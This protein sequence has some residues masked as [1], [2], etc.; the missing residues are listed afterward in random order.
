MNI[1]IFDIAEQNSDKLRKQHQVLKDNSEDK[2]EL[3]TFCSFTEMVKDNWTISI[4]MKEWDLLGFLTSEQYKNRY[5]LNTEYGNKLAEHTELKV[6]T[7][8]TLET[9]LKGFYQSRLTFDDTFKDGR[10]FKYCTL[11][12]GGL[13]IEYGPYCIVM[14]KKRAATYDAL[15]F[16]REDSV[17]YVSGTKVDL[18][19]LSQ[20][21]ANKACVHFLAAIKHEKDISG[22]PPNEW[23]S[24]ICSGKMYI[25]AVT[26]DDVRVTDVESVRISKKDHRPYYQ[27]LYESLISEIS[28]YKKYRLA[29]LSG[30]HNLLEKHG[31]K[32]EELN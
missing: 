19:K 18:A 32:L 20:E 23:P 4:N 10:K 22:K 13:G 14:K 2:S 26:T 1:N 11:N 7:Q 31:I 24:I 25:E 6:S 21:I 17:N 12:I 16:I 15:A 8:E 27:Y 3:G 28:T 5:E 9:A 29:V 30:I